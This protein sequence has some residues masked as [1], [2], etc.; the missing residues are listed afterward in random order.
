MKYSFTS[1][2]RYSEIGENRKLTL[3]ALINYYQDCSN[4]QSEEIGLGIDWL[5]EAKRA[6]VLAAWQI[7]IN[8]YPAMGEQTVI[9]TWAYDFKSF[10]GMRSFTME[11][12]KG[13]L[14]AYANSN[15]VYM[16][17]ETGHPERIP[18]EV[19]D[20]YGL[21]EGFQAD[22]GPR[23]IQI[24]KDGGKT[25]ESF[26]VMEY[27]LDTNHHVNNGQYI[28]MAQGYLPADFEVRKMRAE[29]KQQAYLGDGMT[30]VLYE[31][32]D[33][34][35]VTLNDKDGKPYVSVEFK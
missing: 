33:G 11:D 35:L 28:Q 25:S 17:L 6:W 3:P 7:H 32:A 5:N 20:N 29:Y 24:P 19:V 26:T 12:D 23:K 10:Q 13:E 31:I 8:R 22:F 34:Y 18:Q 16:N 15:W 4:F 27:H 2:I 9:S 21:T 14:L 1:R 30:P